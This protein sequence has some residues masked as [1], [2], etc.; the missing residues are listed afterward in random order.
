MTW[1]ARARAQPERVEPGAQ[2]EPAAQRVRVVPV[3]WRARAQPGPVTR[4]VLV[5]QP[6]PVARVVPAARAVPE[7]W[8][9]SAVRWVQAVPKGSGMPGGPGRLVPGWAWSW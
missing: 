2:P 4:V 3:T 6:E 7:G 8:P 1:R 9:V 5:A